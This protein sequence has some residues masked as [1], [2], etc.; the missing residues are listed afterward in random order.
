[1]DPRNYG[2]SGNNELRTSEIDGMRNACF[3]FLYHE[4]SY[5][6]GSYILGYGIK[7][8]KEPIVDNLLPNSAAEKAGIMKNDKII[9]FNG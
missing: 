3:I 5:A 1:V 4:L 8:D 9:E 6:M 2:Y 7:N